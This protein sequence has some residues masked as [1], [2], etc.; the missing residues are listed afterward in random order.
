MSFF[1]RLFG[2]RSGGAPRADPADRH[3]F[4]VHV[5]CNAC[6]EPVR[7][8]INREH[9]LSGEYSGAGDSP[10]SYH[11]HKEVVGR[12]CFR[13]IGLDLTFDGQRRPTEQSATG[14]TII[15][16]EEFEAAEAERTV[17]ATSEAGGPSSA[18]GSV[19]ADTTSEARSD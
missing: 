7:V 10:T 19:R 2:G 15:T 5:R 1:K 13:R 4:Y 6:G 17:A 3:A 8:R 16:R 9:D 18:P 12:D 14:G 11:V